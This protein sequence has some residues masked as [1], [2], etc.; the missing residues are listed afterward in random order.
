MKKYID[1]TCAELKW[2]IP[3]NIVFPADKY[4]N[5]NKNYEVREDIIEGTSYCLELLNEENKNKKPL[6]YYIND[7]SIGYY[8]LCQSV[9]PSIQ[10]KEKEKLLM[11]L[12]KKAD[13]EFN[14]N[15]DGIVINSAIGN[16][17]IYVDYFVFNDKIQ[18]TIENNIK[19]VKII[20]PN[21]WR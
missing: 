19:D 16:A 17:H 10:K 13:L 14:K 2:S 1:T 11:Q 20:V 5:K 21:E 7:C 12:E 8:S 3:E 15:K 4:L 18:N 9:A 6:H